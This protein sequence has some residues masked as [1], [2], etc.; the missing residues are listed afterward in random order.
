[1]EI[2]KYIELL[3]QKLFKGL[4]LVLLVCSVSAAPLF[5]SG[6]LGE[7]GKQFATDSNV[8]DKNRNIQESK[9]SSTDHGEALSH[10]ELNVYD[11]IKRKLV[12]TFTVNI[13]ENSEWIH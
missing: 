5:G 11:D 9:S 13:E 3:K 7:K 12:A 6:F 4:L 8:S 1:M 2:P 10:K